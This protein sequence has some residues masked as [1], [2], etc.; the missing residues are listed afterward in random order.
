MYETAMRVLGL[1]ALVPTALFL[2]LGFFVMF[3]AARLPPGGVQKFGHAV[4]AL[5]CVCAAMVFSVGAYAV[6]TGRHPVVILVQALLRAG[7]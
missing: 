4:A 2:T 1:F 3:A 7:G 6:L 5:L